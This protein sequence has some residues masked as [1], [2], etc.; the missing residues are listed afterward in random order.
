L[1]VYGF[2]K[3]IR[4]W[5][6]ATGKDLRRIANPR[7]VVSAVA[8]SRDAK[9]LAAFCSEDRTGGETTAHLWDIATGQ[10]VGKWPASTGRVLTFSPDGKGLTAIGVTFPPTPEED[11]TVHCWD[12]TTGKGSHF[13]L[14]RRYRVIGTALSP[15]GKSLAL[16]RMDGSIDLCELATGQVRRQF[17]GHQG[18]I[19]SLAFS[20]DG[21]TLLSGSSDTTALVWDVT[22][23]AQD[24]RDRRPP[25]P[26]QVQA[27]WADLADADAIKAYQA[28]WNLTAAPGQA[29]PWLKDRLKPVA[30]AD[31][32]HVAR[33]IAD[34]D[35][36]RFLVRDK[37]MGELEKLGES[38][39]GL[40]QKA[41]EGRPSLE[42]RQRLAKLLDKL[43]GLVT[44]A[45]DRRALRAVEVLEHIGTAEARQV[46]EAVS[47]G[48]PEA[49]LTREAKAALERLAAGPSTP[50]DGKSMM[51][52][53]RRVFSDHRSPSDATSCPPDRDRVLSRRH[54][55][56]HQLAWLRLPRTQAGRR[57]RRELWGELPGGG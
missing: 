55:G 28:L 18:F 8:F 41:V 3:E 4:L 46:L 16:G 29:V 7:E 22:G 31:P 57:R 6:V 42:T 13:T 15:D 20:A 14:P 10:E 33:L 2:E 47:R 25:S 52:S 40:L 39:H 36:E 51:R 48:V 56:P 45:E 17:T 34:L 9:Q 43:D 49:R 26:E 11:T 50:S 1:V 19:P 23:L 30:T 24:R 37:A 53:S 5:E 35:S 38:A 44:A 21:K 54:P 27:W 32:H 12:V